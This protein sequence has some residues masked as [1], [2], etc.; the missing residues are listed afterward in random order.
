MRAHRATQLDGSIFSARTVQY[1]VQ[2]CSNSRLSTSLMGPELRRGVSGFTRKP[3]P[4]GRM[5]QSIQAI[6]RGAEAG[7]ARARFRALFC[8]LYRSRYS[9]NKK[10]TGDCGAFL[11]KL[12]DEPRTAGEWIAAERFRN[13]WRVLLIPGL[14]GECIDDEVPLFRDSARALARH[15]NV[16]VELLDTI[17]GRA[18]SE[19]NARV[20]NDYLLNMELAADEKLLLIGYSKGTTD[21]LHLLHEPDRYGEAIARIDAFVALAGIVKGTPLADATSPMLERLIELIPYGD[22][23]S[24]DDSGIFDVSREEQLKMLATLHMPDHIRT[25]SLPAFTRRKRISLLLRPTYERLR[26]FDRRNDGQVIVEDAILPG[27]E[28]LGLANADHWAIALPFSRAEARAGLVT[29][30]LSLLANRNHYPRDILLES[31]VR[32]I[33][34]SQPE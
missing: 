21:F 20:M 10:K 16:S 27:S 19:H 33:D 12:K 30:L 34:Q 4:G 15:E 18:S 26:E 1:I 29:R 28:L 24:R 17:G 6:L 2:S 31:I 9:V 14:L 11:H 13:R 5:Q 23:P 8:A 7:D 32:Y 3:L 25:F 22:C